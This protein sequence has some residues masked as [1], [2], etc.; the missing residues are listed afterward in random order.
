MA[1]SAFA[2][3]VSQGVT[4]D[5]Q[6]VA[7]LNQSVAAAGGL[8]AISSIEDFTGI[9]TITYYWADQQVQCPVT[10]RGLGVSDFRLDASLPAGTRTWAASGYSGVLIGTDGAQ[11]S[12]PF[13]N[14]TTAGSLTLPYTRI[15]AIL[16]DS[17]TSISY[18]GLVTVSGQQLQQVHFALAVDP[19]IASSVPL[20]GLGTFD[21][22]FD[23]TSFLVTKLTETVWSETDFTT[24]LPHEIDFTNYQSAGGIQAPLTVTEIVNGQTTWAVTLSSL[25]YNSGLTDSIFNP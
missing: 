7:I 25:T 22:Y 15:A 9:G 5:P 2:R 18:V 8:P 20:S 19:K 11:H 12:S 16:S 6:A 14:L 4:R 17:S 3:Q 10:V 1:A 23:S 21:M 24:T 13:Y